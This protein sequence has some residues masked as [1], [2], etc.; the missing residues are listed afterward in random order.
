ML[1][2]IPAILSPDQ[3]D[4]MRSHLAGAAWGD[5]AVTAGFQSGRV[6][7][8]LQIGSDNPVGRELG[9]VVI[10]ALE[11][12]PAFMSAALPRHVFPPLFNR[13]DAGM[14]FG[15]HIDNAVRQVPGT[16]LSICVPNPMPAS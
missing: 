3:V 9:L 11:T 7:D 13:Y 10:R 8:N 16:A 12:S 4:A 6:K 2:H 5:G 14:G 1:V 15:T